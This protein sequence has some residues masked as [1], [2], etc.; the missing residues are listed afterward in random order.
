MT[1]KAQTPASPR[2]RRKARIPTEDR[3]TRQALH[4]LERYTSSRDNLKRVLE[5]KILRAARDH[6]R[7]VSEFEPLIDIVLA[8]CERAGLVDDT[9]FA[10]IK[11]ASLRRRGRSRRQI[12]AS[13][14]TKGVAPDLI[15][16]ALDE[17][18][19]IDPSEDAEEQAARTYARKRCLGPYRTRETTED[20]RQKDLAAMCRAGYS[21]GLA[22]RILSE[23]IEINDGF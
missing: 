9:R 8:K 5:R 18:E 12:V 2:D 11:V 22:Q 6:D 19:E 21:Y 13:L 1:T 23:D 17:A 15:D 3:L 7:E 20:L 10:E 14:R 4:Y 16:K